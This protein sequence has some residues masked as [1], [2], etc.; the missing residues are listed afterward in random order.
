MGLFSKKDKATKGKKDDDFDLDDFDFSEFDDLGEF[1]D[2]DGGDRVPSK[3][4]LAKTMS[5]SAFDS[6]RSSMKDKAK[7]DLLP[8]GMGDNID[9]L[10]NVKDYT[11]DVIRETSKEINKE[12]TRILPKKWREKFNIGNQSDPYA[13]QQISQQNIR[14]A[15][16]KESIDSI[17]KQQGVM[18]NTLNKTTE[19][20]AQANELGTSKVQLEVL[21]RTSEDVNKLT[22][23]MMTVGNNYFKKSLELQYKSYYNQLDMLKLSGDYFKGFSVQFDKIVKNTGLPDHVKLNNVERVEGRFKEALTDKIYSSAWSNNKYAERLRNK[24]KNKIN[25]VKDDV[26]SMTGF[27]PDDD[28]DEMS[29]GARWNMGASMGGSLL[30]S[31]ASSEVGK[32]LF[33]RLRQRLKANQTVNTT[34]FGLDNLMNGTGTSLEMLRKI[35]SKKGNDAYGDEGFKGWSK[36]A[37]WGAIEALTEIGGL[38]KRDM[39]LGKQRVTDFNKPA[40]FDNNVHNTI[41]D[42]IP[43]MLSRII[44]NTSS[45]NTMYAHVNNLKVPQQEDLVYNYFD[46]KLSSI[47][48]YKDSV[49]RVMQNNKDNDRYYK[50]TSN[51]ILEAAHKGLSNNA[52]VNSGGLKTLSSKKNKESLTEYIKKMT[53]KGGVPD[54]YEE[55]ID[56]AL[57]DNA[58]DSIKDYIK[59]HPEMVK[60][61]TEVKKGVSE[62]TEASKSIERFEGTLSE[63][64]ADYPIYDIKELFVTASKLSG[65]ET[66]NKLSDPQARAISMAWVAYLSDAN[67]HVIPD[68][69]VLKRGLFAKLHEKDVTLVSKVIA[70]F[71]DDVR[72]ILTSRNPEKNMILL[73]Y[74][75]N[76]NNA[77]LARTHRSSGED[78]ELNEMKAINDLNPDLLNRSDKAD[79]NVIMSRNLN[80]TSETRLISSENLDKIISTSEDEPTMS[81]E[82][83]K[84]YVKFRELGG[85]GLTKAAE[86]GNVVS[87]RAKEIKAK[88]SEPFNKAFSSFKDKTKELND[89]LKVKAKDGKDEVIRNMVIG[90]DK[91]AKSSESMLRTS[92]EAYNKSVG[93]LNVLLAAIPD[94]GGSEAR[95]I[96]DM[97]DELRTKYNE[98]SY[99]IR[100]IKD[101]IETAKK[102]LEDLRNSS[103]SLPLKKFLGKVR[104]VINDARS[105]IDNLIDEI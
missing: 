30:G 42:G 51:T 74:F 1:D 105:K 50:S 73:K 83:Y 27:I 101:I 19:L 21:V 49:T 98:K 16:T 32:R 87:N 81:M 34:A 79:I 95:K 61:L 6:F 33:P 63:T 94:Q 15:Q 3:K 11:Q 60:I 26:L 89:L 96:E 13:R 62:N 90:L 85:N 18:Q 99:K 24:I 97:I 92:E 39:S 64:K 23:Y 68:M 93:D 12:L 59:E 14:D 71:L 2:D 25:D 41:T 76:V 77:L 57:S 69:E 56:K 36:R 44:S 65:A 22:N 37:G 10:V 82:N 20:L 46:K 55:L 84:P 91:L 102:Q 28:G 8:E 40:I 78:S 38:P 35:A 5:K 45:L 104:G 66:F 7:D 47:Q 103:G 4:D 72:T 48:D 43:R 29:T 75:D 67:K 17:F 52:L 53:T 86:F 88:Y 58:H 80:N 70:R 54:S 31:I 100:R 9:K